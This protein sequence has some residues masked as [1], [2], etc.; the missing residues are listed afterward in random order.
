M[1]IAG[2]KTRFDSFNQTTT[3][4]FE[5]QF[6]PGL[7]AR[8]GGIDF[9]AELRKDDSPSIVVP[10]P[11]VCGVLPPKTRFGRLLSP[12]GQRGLVAPFH[13]RSH[14][15]PMSSRKHIALHR[16]V[17]PYGAS[18]NVFRATRSTESARTPS[19]DFACRAGRI[20]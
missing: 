12:L 6:S 15:S 14:H 19:S 8:R 13:Q 18:Q 20:A 11:G 4:S 3:S 9:F 5:P 16:T 7:D 17:R 1:A 2:R 10:T